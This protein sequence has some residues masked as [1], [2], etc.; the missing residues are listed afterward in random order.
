MVE[1]GFGFHSAYGFEQFDNRTENMVRVNLLPIVAREDF[2]L[3]R[4]HIA[5]GLDRVANSLQADSAISHHLAVKKH[6]GR[7]CQ[8]NATPSPIGG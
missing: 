8:T 1:A 3:A 2:N 4:A 6:V 7:C 5:R